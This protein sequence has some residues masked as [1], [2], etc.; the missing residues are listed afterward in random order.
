[1]LNEEG[2][3]CSSGSACSAASTEAP[4]VLTALGYEDVLARSALRITLSS[5]N[6]DREID[7]ISRRLPRLIEELRGRKEYAFGK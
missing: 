3:C 1:M 2:I 4:H 7:E 6:T 5:R